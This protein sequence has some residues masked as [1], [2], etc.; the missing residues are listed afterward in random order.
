M[1]I[2]RRFSKE[3][4]DLDKQDTLEMLKQGVAH[5]EIAR[6][7]GRSTQYIVN[8]KNELVAEGLVTTEEVENARKKAIEQKRELKKSAGR[9]I[10]IE[11][12]TLKNEKKAKI[13]E[14]LNSG[15]TVLEI[16]KKL[17]IP[18]TTVKRYIAELVSDGKIVERSI[19]SQKDRNKEESIKRNNL[20]LAD[21]QT[22]KYTNNQLA[23]KYNVSSSLISTLAQGKY[24]KLIAPS[25]K[26]LKSKKKFIPNPDAILSEEEKQV[27]DYLLE[28]QNYN[29]ISK[30]M[31]ISQSEV[32]SITNMLKVKGAISSEQIKNAREDKLKKDEEDVI[33]LL[34]RGYTQ[35]DI[36]IQKR[37][38]INLSRMIS[39]LK[40]EG[41]ITDEE[42]KNAQEQERKFERMEFAELVLNGMKRGLTVKEIIE[43]DEARICNRKAC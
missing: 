7:L 30:K 9:K 28:G 26:K 35:A 2:S 1:A 13:L 21:I 5:A 16:S 3:E 37:D 31:G 32:V 22:G 8:L 18:I 19:V 25:P 36:K 43:S 40:N 6:E 11:K 41:R 15:M 24:E 34:K 33:N 29:F 14:K 10:S 17:G 39:K 42:I 12:E 4:R 23:K 38:T 27:L 20:I